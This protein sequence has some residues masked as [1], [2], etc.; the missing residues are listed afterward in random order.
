MAV[1]QDIQNFDKN[2]K[3]EQK[4]SHIKQKVIH[5]KNGGK[6]DKID[7]YTKLSTMSTDFFEKKGWFFV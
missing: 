7:L 6:C 2:R 3:N 1:V 5:I 4:E